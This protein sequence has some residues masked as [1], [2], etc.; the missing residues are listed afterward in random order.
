MKE[1]KEPKEKKEKKE[2]KGLNL[3][4]LSKSSVWDLQENDVFRLL[5]A[6]E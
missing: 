1:A 6:V 2:E 4:T 5:D 3:K